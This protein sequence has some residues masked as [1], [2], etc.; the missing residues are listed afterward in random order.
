MKKMNLKM[1]CRCYSNGGATPPAD[2]PADPK[3]ADPAPADPKPADPPADPNPADPAKTFTQKEYDDA[4]TSAATA[5]VEKYMKEQA[6]AKDYDKM[7]PEQK[8]AYLESQ[9][10]DRKLSDFARDEI[11][12]AGLPADALAFLKGS[13]E[14]DTTT[15]V[16]AFKTMY[17]AAVQIG[18]DARFKSAGYDP[19][20][21]K[22]VTS[23][24]ET[25]AGAVEAALKI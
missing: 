12:K 17:E 9:A 2:P 22:P 15:K 3:P 4:V 23:S 5:A 24:E 1:L 20:S 21:G 11:S 18:V 10:K 7:T 8:V 6:N 13:D 19:V 16:Q 25:L 14:A